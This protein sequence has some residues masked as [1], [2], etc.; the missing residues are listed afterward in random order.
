MADL[1]FFVEP[2]WSSQFVGAATT[3]NLSELSTLTLLSR[4]HTAMLWGLDLVVGGESAWL[5]RRAARSLNRL[6]ERLERDQLNIDA[7]IGHDDDGTWI[8]EPAEAPPWR[9]HADL[10]TEFVVIDS[11]LSPESIIQE[12]QGADERAR[13][14]MS[15]LAGAYGKRLHWD[16]S[17]AAQLALSV[18]RVLGT[19][20]D[21]EGRFAASIVS[22]DSGGMIDAVAGSAAPLDS[23]SEI[24]EFF[25]EADSEN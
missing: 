13:T 17:G 6:Q 19:W 11:R 21:G 5:C 14:L 12:I 4:T 24:A 18:D 23:A 25:G 20:D 3:V 7:V 8:V 9:D 16:A 2:L 22:R 1:A 10:V 15:P